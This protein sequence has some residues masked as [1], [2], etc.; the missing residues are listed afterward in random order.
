MVHDVAELIIS[1]DQA[2][3]IA[4]AAAEDKEGEELAQVILPLGLM[5]RGVGSGASL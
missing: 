5:P 2:P 3:G 4:A 1:P